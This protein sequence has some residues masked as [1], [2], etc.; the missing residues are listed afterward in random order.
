MKSFSTFCA[1]ALL[2]LVTPTAAQPILEVVFL[3]PERYRDIAPT[4]YLANGRERD[5]ALSLLREYLQHLG[6]KYLREGDRL[7][8]EILDVDL[9]GSLELAPSGQRDVRRM[10]QTGF[11]VIDLRYVLTRAGVEASGEERLADLGYLRH[12]SRCRSGG[13]CYEQIMLAQWFAQRFGDPAPR[14]P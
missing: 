8:I 9:A 11:P 1:V 7:R 4:G 14:A 5:A 10:T 6:K 2:G 12:F 3:N 13:L